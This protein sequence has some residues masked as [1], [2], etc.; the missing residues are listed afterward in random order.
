MDKGLTANVPD[1][2]GGPPL[3]GVHL[4]VVPH[5]FN[6]PLGMSLRQAPEI[7]MKEV[8]YAIVE[9]GFLVEQVEDP[10]QVG[11]PW[12]LT[13]CSP[14]IPVQYEESG[15]A[16]L[17]LLIFLALSFLLSLCESRLF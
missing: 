13:L 1:V 14:L 12:L 8:L 15:A 5:A 9:D 10:H 16:I 4:N 11:L 2:H 17:I 3:L 6:H 7:E